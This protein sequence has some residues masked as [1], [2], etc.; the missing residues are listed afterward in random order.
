MIEQQT[1]MLQHL[2]DLHFLE[3]TEGLVHL[4]AEA[5]RYEVTVQIRNTEAVER[6]AA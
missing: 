5:T 4:Y 1:S 2:Q 6:V 3:L